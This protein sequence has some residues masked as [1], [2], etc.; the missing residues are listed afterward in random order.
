LNPFAEPNEAY[1]MK[2]EKNLLLNEKRL[3]MRKSIKSSFQNIQTKTFLKLFEKYI[4]KKKIKALDIGCS[5]GYWLNILLQYNTNLYGIDLYNSLAPSLLKKV[6]FKI[7]SGTNLPF[8]HNY[9]DLVYSID[10]IEH[11]KNDKKFLDEN[12]RVLKKNGIVILGTPNKTRLSAII[13]LLL[14]HPNKYPLKI[15]DE[16]FGY[17]THIREY[18]LKDLTN[19]IHKTKFKILEVVPIYLG[20]TRYFDKIYLP[21]PKIFKNF[22]QFWFVVLKK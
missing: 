21:Y 5:Y 12:Y 6:K 14:L 16:I 13:K 2:I 8:S 22:C 18:T 19:L 20:F 10:V 4:L 1:L 3:E 15:K 9:F 7:G 11:I 17:I